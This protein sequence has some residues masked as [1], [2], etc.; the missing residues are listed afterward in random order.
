VDRIVVRATP[1]DDGLNPTF[2]GA[3]ATESK[4]ALIE[5]GYRLT[6]H[7]LARNQSWPDS[8]EEVGRGPGRRADPVPMKSGP[9]HAGACDG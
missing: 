6:D 3:W 1:G 8:D 4:L 7:E 2:R 5:R 9:G